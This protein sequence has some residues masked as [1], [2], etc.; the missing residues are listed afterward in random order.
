[1]VK[2]NWL[3]CLL[4]LVSLLGCGKA[5]PAL[6]EISGTVTFKGQPIPAGDVNFTPDVSISGGQSRM[7]MV[8]DGKY[9][10]AQKQKDGS[11]PGGLLPGKYKVRVAGYDGKQVP[12]FMDGKQIFNAIELEMEIGTGKVTQNFEVPDSAGENVKFIETADF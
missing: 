10:S 3:I 6:T 8:K 4:G 11:V 7:Y 12:M 5:A 1:M 2:L 9:D